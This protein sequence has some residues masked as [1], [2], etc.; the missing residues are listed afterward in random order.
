MA[1]MLEIK[2]LATYFFTA[3]GVVKAVD[4]ISYH[5]DEGESIAIVGE[6][7][8]GK[9]VSALSVMRLV[10][11]PPGRTVHG[12]VLFEGQ[13]VLKLSESEMRHVRGN[14]IAMVFQEPMTSLNPVLT[15]GYQL[16]ESLKLHLGMTNAE[17]RERAGDLLKLVGI[18]DAD[19]RLKDYPHQF[20]GGMRQRV[21]IALALG[22][23]PKIII[24]DEPTTALDVTIQAQVLEVMKSLADEFGTALIM[25]THNLG[26]VARYAQRVIVM[27]AG[28]I[29]ESGT[30]KQIYGNPRHPY[31]LG[32]LK[33][34]PRLDEVRREK[35]DPIE[36]LPP[37]LIN[38]PAA[39]SFAP[40]CRYAID[41]CRSE[42]PQL[43]LV[44]AGH[45]SACFR[46]KELA[47]LAK[48]HA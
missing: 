32:L 34:I 30:A 26:V 16:T 28:K 27:Y 47:Q 12:E 19:Q 11:S 14:R 42:L 43:E 37:S 8:C 17:A 23:N 4:G 22:C 36:G 33:S 39:C 13:D 44:E 38:L 10:A 5:V 41:K 9:S 20:S 31:T 40:R 15:I 21:M 46:S 24:A 7:G 35:L 6:S 25:I 45:M 48:A 1:K 2:D 3:D 18:P 29:I